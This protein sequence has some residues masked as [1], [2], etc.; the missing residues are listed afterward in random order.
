MA[1]PD[2]GV[3]A[4]LDGLDHPLKPAVVALRKVVLAVDPAIR[5]AIKWNAPS[6]LATEHFA[7]MNLRAQ[8]SL[9]LVLHL[10]AKKRTHPKLA[11]EDPQ[12]LLTW[13]GADRA[14]IAFA[15]VRDVATKAPAL[16]AVLRQWM[17]YA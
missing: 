2:P 8:D 9:L 10:G 13:L 3:A 17:A 11:I 15:D 4:F 16:R 12:R 6:F 14:S 1:K 5:E 7:T